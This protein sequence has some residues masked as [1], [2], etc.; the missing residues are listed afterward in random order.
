MHTTVSV[1]AQAAKSGSQ[2]PLWMLGSPRWLGISLKHTAC[3]VAANYG[4]RELR[5]PQRHDHQRD[6]AAPG[7]A[8][9]LLDHPV[10]V[11]LDAREAEV[12]VV[13]LG[14]RLTAEA[15]K[16]REAQRGVDPV[17]I[18]VLESRLRLVA[19]RSHLVVR[20]RRH[21]H[22][23]AVEADGR[24]VPLV[25][26]DEVAEDPTVGLRSARVERLLVRAAPDVA[27][28][29][30]STAF[31]ARACVAPA[32]REPR[33]PEVRRLHHVVVDADDLGQCT[34]VHASASVI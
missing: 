8:A 7:V 5:I 23:V 11:G 31:G 14:E 13:D 34:R 25:D 29:A 20:D 21:R 33:L 32:R 28:R 16:G 22:V 9:P 12:L 2:A 4:G 24:H 10:V 18:H 19:A 3:R 30:D 27:H 6:E 26:V 1:S 17:Q 15:R